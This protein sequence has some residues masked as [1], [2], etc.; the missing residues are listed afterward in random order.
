[1]TCAP[2]WLYHSTGG[3]R[4]VLT[5]SILFGKAWNPPTAE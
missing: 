1:M 3:G 4:P 5:V 2:P